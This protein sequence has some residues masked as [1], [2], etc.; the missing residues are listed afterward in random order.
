LYADQATSVNGFLFFFFQDFLLISTA[1]ITMQ[2]GATPLFENISAKFGNGNRYGLIGANGCGKSTFMKILSGALT[3]TSGNVSIT[4]G[5]KVGTLS[6]DQFAF[7]E[8]SVV[9]AVIMG[10]VALW[11]IK[12]ERDAIYSKP[13]MSEEDGM[14]AGELEAEFAEMDGYS[15][16]SRAGDILLEAGIEENHHFSLMSQVAP[17]WK[18]RVLLAQALFANPDILLLDEPT[19]NLDIHTINWLADVLNQ[20]KCTMI[21]ISHDRHFLNSV[22][23][24]M[25]DIDFG[26]LRIYPGNYEYFMEASSLIREQLLTENSKKSAEMEDLQAFVN[27]F[28]ANASKAKQASSR[29]KK[30]DKIELSEVKQSS[31]MTPSLNFKQDKKLHRQALILEELGHGYEDELLFTDGSIILDAGARLAIIGENG[32]GKT[33]FLRCLIN[34]LEAKQGAIKWAE[35]AVIGYCP[36]DST[37]DFNSDLT[38][39]DWMSKWRTVKHDDLKVRAMLGRLLFTADDFNK[40]VR[41][42]SGGEKNRLLFGKLMMMDLNV[43]IMDEPTNHMDMEAIE[44]LNNALIDFDGTLIFVSHDRAFVSSL[45]N[46]VIEIK[47]QQIIDFQGTYDEY[48]AHQ[49]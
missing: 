48:L 42:C 39:F 45:A 22:C 29:A 17:G 21:I 7:E 18:L 12:Q 8:Y 15:A 38:L 36:Q 46:R 28:S 47:G 4:P 6:Q 34:E 49:A 16:E 13:E 43:L 1:N 9:D 19:N 3:P 33:T 20:R 11:K 31:R 30:L 37:E 23:T 32:A 40:K 41:V 44:A 25:A 10:D 14:R 27:R 35:N 5:E 2:F 26:E 24:H